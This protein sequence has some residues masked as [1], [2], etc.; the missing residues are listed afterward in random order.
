MRFYR[1]SRVR[2]SGA[3]FTGLVTSD[4]YYQKLPAVIYDTWWLVVTG[5]MAVF[6]LPIILIGLI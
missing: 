4:A 3:F 6:M 5:L 1:S 2:D